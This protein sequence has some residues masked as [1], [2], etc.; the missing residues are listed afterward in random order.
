[1]AFTTYRTCLQS[2]GLTT[3]S[4][5]AASSASSSPERA[6]PESA[7][8]SHALSTLPGSTAG[9]LESP[10][11]SPLAASTATATAASGMRASRPSLQPAQ[12]L[13]TPRLRLTIART[14][15]PCFASSP[16]PLANTPS[17]CSAVRSSARGTALRRVRSCQAHR[18]GRRAARVRFWAAPAPSRL[19]AASSSITR[20]LPRRSPASRLCSACS[21][22]TRTTTRRNGGAPRWRS[23]RTGPRRRSLWR[24]PGATRRP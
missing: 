15:P 10:G 19:C 18:C 21:P 2:Q 14:A 3:S 5:C 23:R 4:W 1:M 13:D 17:P 11:L 12:G 6:T 9:R 20:G 24:C 16:P 7:T 8:S 22:A